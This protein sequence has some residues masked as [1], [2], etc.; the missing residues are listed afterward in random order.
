VHHRSAPTGAAHRRTNVHHRSAPMGAAQRIGSDLASGS[1]SALMQ[2][3]M[4]ETC[5]KRYARA[6]ACVRT[7]ICARARS[8]L[9][10]YGTGTGWHGRKDQRARGMPIDGSCPR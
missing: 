5:E 3:E 9:C 6:K 7:S 1:A 2:F 4:R 10:V 8:G